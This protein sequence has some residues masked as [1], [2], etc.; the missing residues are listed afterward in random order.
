MDALTSRIENLWEGSTYTRHPA[1]VRRDLLAG[2]RLGRELSCFCR[3]CVH[4]RAPASRCGAR[5]HAEAR[6]GRLSSHMG[7]IVLVGKC[8]LL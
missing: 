8:A 3:V 6:L 1:H 5:A 7:I 2:V 4:T